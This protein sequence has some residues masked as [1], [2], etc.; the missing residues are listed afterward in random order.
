MQNKE[1]MFA[2]EP[3]QL[4]ELYARG[5]QQIPRAFHELHTPVIAAVNGAAIGA[6][7]D[8][9]C[10]CDIRYAHPKAK[11]GET[12]ANLGLIPGDGGSY[13]LQKIIGFA[14]AMELS[15]TGEVIGAEK[16]KELSL[17][18]YVGEDFLGHAQ[19]C[20]KNIANKPPVAVQMLKRAIENAR[21]TDLNSHLNLLSAYQGITQRT[22]DHFNALSALIDQKSTEYSHK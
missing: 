12:F 7:L 18:T 19:K 20:A 11:F 2:G 13:F 1:G 10:M 17:V 14:H 22:S 9:A 16:A 4:R 21:N 5:I 3:N 6:G 15:L 8:L